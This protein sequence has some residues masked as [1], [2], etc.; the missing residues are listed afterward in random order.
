[1][2]LRSMPMAIAWRTF[3]LSNGLEGIVHANVED[4]KRRAGHELQIGVCLDFGEIIRADV[5]DPIYCA[6]LQLQQA[7]GGFG[8]PAEDQRW[9]T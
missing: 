2:R 4:V 8:A 5:I 3:S 1:M 6:G 9:V 7:L